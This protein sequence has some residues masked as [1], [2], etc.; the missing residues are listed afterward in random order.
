[1]FPI[2]R[3]QHPRLLLP[4]D[5]PVGCFQAPG[6]A[7][8]RR[9]RRNILLD[10]EH[11]AQQRPWPRIPRKPDSPHPYH[12]LYLTFY[13]GM[14]TTA[15]LE[16]YAFAFRLTQ[17]RR[18]LQCA[19]RWLRAAARYDH[20][21][22]VEEHFYTANR[23]LQAIAMAL[24]LLHDVLPP[25]DAKGARNCLIRILQRW[26][27]DVDRQRHSPE[28]GHHAVVDN[29]HFGV[30]GLHLLGT[31]PQAQD[32][33]QAVVDRFRAAIMP[34]GCGRAGEPVDG[35][36]FW[37]WENLWML[38]FADA[39]RN[40]TGVDLASEFPSRLRRPLIWFR[41]HLAAPRRIRDQLYTPANANVLLGSQL[42]AC[43]PALLR[44][45]QEAGDGDLRESALSDPRLGRLYRFGAGV[46]GSSAECM[47]AYG[48]YAYCYCD[49]HFE[50]RPIRRA[51]P[52]ARSYSA[53]YGRTAILRSSRA[54]AA[55]IACVSGYDGG[56]AH[57]FMNLHV[58]WMGH[59]VLRSISAAEAQ[60]V[61]CGSLPCVGGQNEV[62][63]GPG[64]IQ[65]TADWQRLRVRSRRTDHEY[66][67]LPARDGKPPVLLVAL[68]RR[69]RHVRVLR[70]PEPVFR[71]RGD[72]LQVPSA[73]WFTPNQG[74]LRLRVRLGEDD[75]KHR[76][77]FNTGLGVGGI[78]GAG[79][80]TFAL[81][82][83][84]DRRLRFTVESQRGHVVS[85]SGHRLR[86]G[87]WHEITI[88]W[89]GVNRHGA[90]PGL[91]LELNG[92]CWHQDDAQAFGEMGADSIGLASRSTP[93]TFYVRPHTCLAFG[94]A[95]QTPGVSGACDLA[96]VDLQCPGRGRLRLDPAL[97]WGPETGG[98]SL[99]YKLNPVELRSFSAS[100]ARLGAGAGMVELRTVYG[101][102][103]RLTCE[104]VPFAPS[105]L[106]AGSLKSFIDG[107][108]EAAQRLVATTEHGQSMVLAFCARGTKIDSRSDSHADGFQLYQDGR[109]LAF[110][111]A[112]SGAA[113]LVPRDL[114]PA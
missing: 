39:L 63:A 94:G 108:G 17:D 23:Y 66:W 88:R 98:T 29:G 69:R 43:S 102:D 56:T 28:G 86:V 60:P 61:G 50:P 51:A 32:W 27:P 49:P 99:S 26:W 73:K 6:D 114:Q 93:R 70:D 30:A 97:G 106:A 15:L 7:T 4:A 58:Q 87:R 71:L 109:V 13:T 85:V 25:A 47:I 89:H 80:N 24:D 9:I 81:V 67:M 40:V 53:H 111:V 110:D 62:V 96:E 35:P 112:G 8:R 46:K 12:Q 48:P 113:I 91:Q 83:D 16:H 31:H 104:T 68:R 38:Q 107:T 20:D 75:G 77:L 37:P 2:L 41:D 5:D 45:A 92:R 18:W 3:S 21:D 34:H 101:E 55:A 22:R 65:I 78:G 44:L 100:A 95:V 82:V 72:A 36:T 11:F 103:V 84:P 64:P 76:V 57:G 10:C 54:P 79:V 1:M 74:Q 14:H 90:Q 105:G 42:D 33:V 19:L 52:L 59:P